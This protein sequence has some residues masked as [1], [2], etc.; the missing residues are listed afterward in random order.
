[1]N[2]SII[3]LRGHH[4]LTLRH[5]VSNPEEQNR[6][7]V[8]HHGYRQ[9]QL[10]EELVDRLKTGLPY[11]RI[12][13]ER[14]IFCLQCPTYDESQCRSNEV[15]TDDYLGARLFGLKINEVYSGKRVLDSITEIEPRAPAEIDDLLDFVHWL[16]FSQHRSRTYPS[17]NYNH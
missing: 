13:A 14:D 11:V 16:D 3:N 17:L 10:A 12:V 4:L 8:N 2:G 7:I 6:V 5:L 9:A 15:L 1:M